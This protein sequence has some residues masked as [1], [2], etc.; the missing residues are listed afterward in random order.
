MTIAELAR[1]ADLSKA[2]AKAVLATK[3]EAE[4]VKAEL[5]EL[6]TGQRSRSKTRSSRKHK[7]LKP[8][9]QGLTGEWASHLNV[10]CRYETK[11][12]VQDRDDFRHNVILELDRASKRDGK[13]LPLLRAYRIASLTVALYYRSLNRFNTRVCVYNGYPQTLHC[14]ACQNKSEG[15]RCC[16]L[17]VRPIERLDNEILD[18]EGYRVK[19]LD[20]VA[21]DKVED[22]PD[23][24]YELNELMLG[25]PLRL[26][27]IACKRLDGKPLDK[28]DQKYLERYRKKSQMALP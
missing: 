6:L 1:Q 20:T 23:K 13:P 2:E 25:L 19:L 8:D 24:W 3:W 26:V 9:Y 12:P 28:K 22:M 27:E 16:W 7:V 18:P 15:N 21:S 4:A 14:K 17:A 5:G 10:A 11:I